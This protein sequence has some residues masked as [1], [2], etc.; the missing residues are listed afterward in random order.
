MSYEVTGG[1]ILVVERVTDGF[2]GGFDGILGGSGG[3]VLPLLGTFCRSVSL[4][5]HQIWFQTLNNGPTGQWL[6]DKH[7]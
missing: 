4:V 6:L 5:W 7:H 2:W 3:C 1:V